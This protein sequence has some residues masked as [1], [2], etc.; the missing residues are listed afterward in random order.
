MLGPLERANLNHWSSDPVSKTSCFYLLI[1]ESG[2]WT[3]SENPLILCVIHP[4]Q[5]PKESI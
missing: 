4:R 5:N 1:L 3:K 2:R